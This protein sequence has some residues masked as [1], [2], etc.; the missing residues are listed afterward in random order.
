MKNRSPDKLIFGHLNINSLRNK[1]DS[2]K[3]TIGRNIDIVLIFNTKLDYSFPSAKFKIDGFNAAFT[4]DRNRKESGLLMDV[5]ENIP[6]RQLFCKSKFY[7]DL[8]LYQLKPIKKRK[9]FLNG[10]YNPHRKSISNHLDSLNFFF[11]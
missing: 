10:S 1:F 2:L 3:N 7:I 5:R 4:I 6:S 8:R 9:W 11:L